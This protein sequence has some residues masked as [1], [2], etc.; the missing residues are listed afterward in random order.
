MQRTTFLNCTLALSL[1]AIL[2]HGAPDEPQAEHKTFTVDVPELPAIDIQDPQRFLNDLMLSP[3]WYVVKEKNGLR[4]DP[5]F[6]AYARS[7]DTLAFSSELP[8]QFLFESISTLPE[9]AIIKNKY[10]RSFRFTTR[11]FDTFTVKIVFEKPSDSSI[12]ATAGQTYSIQKKRQFFGSSPTSLAFKISTQ[13][14]IYL[15]VQEQGKDPK[16]TTTSKKLPLTF[17]ELQRLTALPEKY[18]VDNC[19]ADFFR[20]F[21]EAPFKDNELKR[22]LS[23]VGQGGDAFYGYFRAKP[24]VS[25]NGI[26]I[27]ISHPEYCPTEGTRQSSRL[28][29]AEYL[30][31]PYEPDDILFFHIEDNYT[32]LPAQY[33]KRFG[34]ASG[35]EPFDGILEILNDKTNVLLKTT[36]P[37]RS[38]ER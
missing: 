9:K 11:D 38:W 28:W 31:T 23:T 3:F 12:L 4:S 5:K 16:S 26:N 1:F 22:F 13:H 2:A 14:D 15:L 6:V 34:W 20:M 10:I 36:Q 8:P 7:L 18:R 37:F 19:Y 30:G 27:K 32:Y 35:N 29:K 24:D 21:F 33:T 17:R 25:Y